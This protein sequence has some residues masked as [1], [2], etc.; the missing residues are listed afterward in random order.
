MSL[1]D[2]LMEVASSQ[3][4]KQAAQQTGL[5]EGMAAKMMP[6]AM[7]AILGGLKKNAS[8]PQGAEAL[9]NALSKHDGGL[10]DNI[11]QLGN[12]DIMNDGQKI[13]G[14]ILGGKQKAAEESIAKAAGGVSQSQAKDLMAMV[15]PIVLASLGKA[16]K[17][18]G[19][20]I[21]ALAGLV[22]N[23]GAKAQESAGSELTGLM[24]MLDADGDGDIKDEAFGIGKKLLGGLFKR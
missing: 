23:E 19:L 7:S 6:M 11:G 3:I 14:H 21:S 8:S 17:E 10:L 22:Q 1:M 5:A 4:T 16:K 18:Q 2:Q 15:A 12:T 13:L 9:S 24:A 20:D